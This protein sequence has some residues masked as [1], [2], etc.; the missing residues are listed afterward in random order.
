MTCKIESM[1]LDGTRVS[2]HEALGCGRFNLT[3]LGDSVLCV[4]ERTFAQTF[5]P[6]I[7]IT[8]YH[9]IAWVDAAHD[10]LL[11]DRLVD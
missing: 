6:R 10:I 1:P 4:E 7:A 3:Y 9:Q 11:I 2:Q 5:S 8:S